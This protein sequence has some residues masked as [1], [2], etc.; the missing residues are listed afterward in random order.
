MNKIYLFG[1][2]GNIG[3]FFSKKLSEEKF[4]IISLSRKNKKNFFDL[5]DKDCF[6]IVN[7]IDDTDS[8]I[9]LSSVSSKSF[10]Q[11]YPKE[12]KKINDR[13][14]I[15]LKKLSKTKCKIIFLSSSEV[16]SGKKDGYSIYD[17]PNPDSV[18][19]KLKLEIE[20]F[21]KKEFKKF[22]IIRTGWIINYK[23][24]R[25]RCVITDTYYKLLTKSAEFAHDNFISIL[26]INDSYTLIKEK[27][28]SKAKETVHITTINKISRKSLADLIIKY[29]S[30]NKLKY[31]SVSH[32]DLPFY[33]K[34]YN[35]LKNNNNLNFNPEMRKIKK[36]ISNKI[37]KIDEKFSRSNF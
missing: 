4:D 11:N 35:C 7:Q 16:F 23:N 6:K 29:S 22:L 20:K 28:F 10:A 30:N 15:F 14:K 26:N 18:Y 9:F 37:I 2:R 24:I 36:L 21:I 25:G 33:I 17:A 1:S 34:Q 13:S 31:K 5:F 3:S 19:G 32:K 12:A 27:L 8:V